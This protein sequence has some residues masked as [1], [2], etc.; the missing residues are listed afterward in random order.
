VYHRILSF[1]TQ[2][3]IV[4]LLRFVA[5]TII[6]I[7][8]ILSGSSSSLSGMIGS[9]FFVGFG[10]GGT[11]IPFDL[12]AEFLPSSH[13]GRF[14]M[15]IEGFFTLGSVFVTMMAWV[16]LYN[17]GWQFLTLMTAVPVT[18][19]CIVSMIFLPES[20]RWHLENGRVEEAETVLRA[21]C[22]VNRCEYPDH[23]L[24]EVTSASSISPSS[25]YPQ[26]R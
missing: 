12:L 14:L 8:W 26:S 24:Q 10:I 21:M 3:L 16:A 15:Y 5:A 25:A 11:A 1:N 22:R 20:A 18:L 9:R 7:S 23:A 4:C 2:Y 19:T 13:R 6:S 17:H